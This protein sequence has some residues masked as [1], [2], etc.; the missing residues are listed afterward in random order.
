P[1]FARAEGTGKVVTMVMEGVADF[2]NYLELFLPK[3]MNMAIIPALIWVYIA[4]QDWTS[5]FILMITLPILIVFMIILGLAAKKQADSQ[6]ETYRVLSN[7]FV[8]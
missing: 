7:H 2:R 4:F 1:R 3:M 5:A 6:F 8:D